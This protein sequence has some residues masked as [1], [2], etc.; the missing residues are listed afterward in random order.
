MTDVNI[1]VFF[2]FGVLYLIG[3]SAGASV[4][5]IAA[6]IFMLAMGGTID[7]F[8]SVL[9]NQT[10]AILLGMASIYHGIVLIMEER[11]NARRR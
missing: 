6:G 7:L 5:V 1:I 9:F 2:V 10:F 4:L 11:K 8:G 3:F